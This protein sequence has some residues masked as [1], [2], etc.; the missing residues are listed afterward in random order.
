VKRSLALLAASCLLAT[1]RGPAAA[2]PPPPPTHTLCP[3]FVGRI[4]RLDEAGTRYA[5]GLLTYGESGTT[6]GTI[7]FFAGDERYEVPFAN[8]LADDPTDAGASPEPIV[9]QFA[10]PVTLTAAVVAALGSPP[11]ACSAPYMPWTQNG[12]IAPALAHEWF[13]SRVARPSP[14][15]MPADM[16]DES[17]LWEG[18]DAEA[19]TASAVEAGTPIAVAPC[20][21]KDHVP[22]LSGRPGLAWMPPLVTHGP[23]AYTTDV[24]VAIDADGTL[25]NAATLV[26]SSNKTF[27]HV[28]LVA[29][30]QST[31]RAGQFRCAPVAGSYVFEFS[32]EHG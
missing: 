19:R 16:L 13:S 7:A 18:F 2:A 32:Y 23:S 30:Q 28:A 24:L 14:G 1:P 8:A 27:D 31:F 5:V 3:V 21:Q 6:S 9:V 29:A 20:A 12:R 22:S 15:P 10:R 26:S 25:L 17:K 11:A 4:D